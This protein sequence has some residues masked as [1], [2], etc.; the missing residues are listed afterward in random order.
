MYI[1][2]YNC[3]YMW[4]LFSFKLSY[5]TTT[6]NFIMIPFYVLKEYNFA[7][8]PI[9]HK[10]N[11]KLLKITNQVHARHLTSSFSTDNFTQVF[12]FI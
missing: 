5:R 10:W 1:F 2:M 4:K 7:R 12:F 11:F 9:Q 8:V 6:L 3:T